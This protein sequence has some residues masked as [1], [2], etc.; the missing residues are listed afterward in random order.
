MLSPKTCGCLLLKGLFKDKSAPL[1]GSCNC[2]N[3]PPCVGS[4]HGLFSVK[5]DLRAGQKSSKIRCVSL[6]LGHGPICINTSVVFPLTMRH[7]VTAW[8]DQPC[9][10]RQLGWMPG[11]QRNISVIFFP[12]FLGPSSYIHNPVQG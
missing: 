7:W 6:L 10:G 5:C 4:N 12:L 11:F 1:Y 3:L 2:L 8:L 9:L